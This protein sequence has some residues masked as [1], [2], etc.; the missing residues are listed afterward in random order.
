MRNER[1]IFTTRNEDYSNNEKYGWLEITVYDGWLAMITIGEGSS[2]YAA[3]E[4]HPVPLSTDRDIGVLKSFLAGTISLENDKCG[5][6]ALAV[7][8]GRTE[9]S[10]VKLLCTR[11]EDEGRPN[12]LSL[13]FCGTDDNP[14]PIDIVAVIPEAD[15]QLALLEYG[16]IGG[17]EDA[18]C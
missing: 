8:H 17:E 4:S 10:A 9:G 11:L 6:L 7:D 15:M 2:E 1:I 16:F 13:G 12:R 3:T 5:Y 18:I 14:Q